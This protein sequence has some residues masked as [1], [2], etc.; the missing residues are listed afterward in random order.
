MSLPTKGSLDTTAKVIT[1]SFLP[2]DLGDVVLQAESPSGNK[3]LILRSVSN[4]KGKKKICWGL[5]D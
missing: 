3:L 2:V 1:S 5:N 4:D